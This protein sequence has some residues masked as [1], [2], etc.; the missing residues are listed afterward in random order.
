M[1]AE[2]GGGGLGQ[3]V[4]IMTGASWGLGRRLACLLAPQLV[5]GSAL[6]LV[7]LSASALGEL[8]DDLHAACP[9]LRVQGLPADL[10]SDKGLQRVLQARQALHSGAGWLQWLLLINNA[11][12]HPPV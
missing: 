4:C 12:E 2:P 6:L 11:G 5:P 10:A 1:E 9:A 3:A 7:V 8:E